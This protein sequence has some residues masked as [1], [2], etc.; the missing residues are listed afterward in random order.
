MTEEKRHENKFKFGIYQGGESL[1]E[2]TFNADDYNPVIRYSVDIRAMLPSII[3][4]CQSLLSRRNLSYVDYN[5]NFLNHYKSGLEHH[6]K[7]GGSNKL[8]KPNSKTINLG[9]KIIKGVECKIGLYINNNPIVERDFYVENYTPSVRFSLEIKNVLDNIICDI[10]NHLKKSDIYH[11]WEDFDIISTYGLN[12]QQVRDLAPYKRKEYLFKFKNPSFVS[13]VKKTKQK[14]IL[15][16]Q[17]IYGWRI[18]SI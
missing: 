15:T 12:I 6:L 8:T 11:M 3:Q 16:N 4:Q 2:Q 14:A 7:L 13:F 10:K 1:I 5:Y 9:K 18:L 17:N